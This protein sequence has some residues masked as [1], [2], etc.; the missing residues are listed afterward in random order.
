MDLGYVK[1]LKLGPGVSVS[2]LHF[3]GMENVWIGGVIFDLKSHRGYVTSSGTLDVPKR[4]RWKR[5][6]GGKEKD[7]GQK[8][9]GD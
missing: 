8:E 6:A 1:V 2:D 5:R 9:N 7:Y 3:E 4:D